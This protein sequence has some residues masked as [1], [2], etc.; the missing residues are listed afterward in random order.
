MLFRS[1]HADVP[2]FSTAQGWVSGQVM[3]RLPKGTPILICEERR[4]GFIGGQKLWLRIQ[5]GQ[6]QEGWTFGEGTVTSALGGQGLL[7][8]AVSFLWPQEAYA[9][10]TPG[11]PPDTNPVAWQFYVL[12][13]GGVCLGMAAK[14]LF[15][16]LEHGRLSL[17]L[18]G[19]KTLSSLLVAPMV[20]QGIL[21]YGD[22]GIQGSTGLF[23]FLG[24]AFQ[25]GFFWQTVLVKAGKGAK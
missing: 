5:F 16:L 4:V 18:Y 1:V 6:G 3:A 22:L 20:L 11:V 14:A 8:R 19:R 23:A 15:D 12:V 13:F 10:E 24:M 9:Q 17:R 2:K 21:Q 25:N 7:P